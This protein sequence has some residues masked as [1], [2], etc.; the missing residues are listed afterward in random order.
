V[1]LIQKTIRFNSAIYDF[2]GKVNIRNRN[3]L[4]L[5]I[6]MK[7]SPEIMCE[8]NGRIFHRI[9]DVISIVDLYPHG[10]CILNDKSGDTWF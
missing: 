2:F 9:Q 3:Y 1:I 10:T 6:E 8:L 5:F 4:M 7:V